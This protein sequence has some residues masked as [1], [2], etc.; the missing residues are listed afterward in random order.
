VSYKRPTSA[1]PSLRDD[2]LLFYPS[3]RGLLMR[4]GPPSFSFA[5]RGEVPKTQ[6]R[7][8][9]C[10]GSRPQVCGAARPW[11]PPTAHGAALAQHLAETFTCYL[12]LE[13][14]PRS[15]LYYLLCVVWALGCAPGRASAARVRCEAT[16]PTAS[17][18]ALP[19]TVRL[20]ALLLACACG[21]AGMHTV[22][23]HSLPS[24]AQMWQQ[25]FRPGAP[26]P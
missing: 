14:P 9:R 15:P 21:L 18:A 12:L 25:V 1:S 23:Y 11:P 22:P 5:A 4:R 16:R 3:G 24:S 19:T 17:A 26:I 7:W 6:S 2:R 20:S 8:C 10:S 13:V